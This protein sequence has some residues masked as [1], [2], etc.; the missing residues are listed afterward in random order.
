MPPPNRVNE[1]SMLKSGKMTIH[2]LPVRAWILPI[3][4]LTSSVISVTAEPKPPLARKEPK[5]IELHGDKRID[6]YFWLRDK[7]SPEVIKYLEDENKYTEEQLADTKPLQEKIYKE[8]VSRIRETDMGVPMKRDDYFYYT[9]TEQ[10]KNYPIYCRK[11][12]SVNGA[13]EILLDA[14]QLAAGQKYFQMGIY[15]VSPD[16]KILAFGTD[17]KGDEEF[18]VRFKDLATGDLLPGQLERVTYGF[19]WAN[20]NKT[21]FYTVMDEARRPFKVFRYQ[22]GQKQTDAHEVFHEKDQRFTVNISR[23]HSNAY[24]FLSVD[25]AT[26]SEVH[27][28]KADTPADGFTVLYPRQQ[29]IEY[30]VIHHDAEFFVRVSDT[31]KNF[32]LVRVPVNNPDKKNWQEVLP[33]RREVMLEGVDAFKDHLLVMERDR[34]LINLRIRKFSTGAEHFVQFPEPAYTVSPGGYV[35]YDTNILRFTY[36]SLVTPSSVFDYN[37]DT[38]T[39]ELKK[40]QEV[41]GGYDPAKYV[42]ERLNASASDGTKIPISIVY[43]RGLKKDGANPAL[44]NGYGSYGIPSDPGFSSAR[45]SLLDR[46][47]VFAIAHIR[48]GGDLGKYWH[49]DGRMLKKRNSFTDFIAAAEYLIKEKY[50]QPSKLAIIGGSAGGLL[51]G[52]VTNMRPDLFGAVVAKVPFVDVLNTMMDATLPLTVGEYEEWGNPADQKFYSYMRSYS[53]YDN[54]E[55]QRFPN[56][57]VTAGLN[58]P[59]VSYWEPAKWVAKLRTLKKGDSLLVLKTNM[60]AGHFGESGRYNQFKEAAFDYAFIIKA[61]GL[62]LE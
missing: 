53:P 33:H 19:A 28:V 10:G 27:F 22:L 8:I 35:E 54:L 21:V 62:K 44:L 48:G 9:R 39:R 14:N 3:V 24:I 45:L 31:G 59:R 16:H 25:S 23:S 41:L 43:R 58:D 61:L 57:L 56:M 30:Q 37:M 6:N 18:V 26:T 50:T 5:A 52:A 13:E 49:E 47:F 46:G 7:S 36:S 2:K 17:V 55:S 40:Q 51:M 11:K 29:D 60:G 4:M 42:S 15:S 1:A 12:G 32:R 20:D 34:G 38:K